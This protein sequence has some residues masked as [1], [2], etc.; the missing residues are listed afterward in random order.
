MT[1]LLTSLLMG[2]P[3]HPFNTPMSKKGRLLLDSIIEYAIKHSSSK[4]KKVSNPSIQFMQAFIDVYEPLVYEEACH[5][6]DVQQLV[7]AVCKKSP[8]AI[9][10]L[11]SIATLSVLNDQ[12]W[13]RDNPLTLRNSVGSLS[14]HNTGIIY[15]WLTNNYVLTDFSEHDLNKIAQMGTEGY[16]LE[17]IKSEAGNVLDNSKKNISY[18]YAI[19]VD[20]TN[21]AG[22]IRNKEKAI[23]QRYENKLREMLATSSTPK[24]QH[25]SQDKKADWERERE[26]IN[27]LLDLDKNDI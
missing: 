16:N 24:I 2:F 19:I 21:R 17:D 5:K 6:Y 3:N 23:D 15:K 8:R 11:V 22:V 10:E 4:I 9:D 18:L 25:Y 14:D 27:V 26:Y 1:P 7:T 20:V 12:A 13:M